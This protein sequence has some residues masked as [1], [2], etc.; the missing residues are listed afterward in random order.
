MCSYLSI[1][2]LRDKSLVLKSILGF[3]SA[4]ECTISVSQQNVLLKA[5]FT[6]QTFQFHWTQYFLGLK[7]QIKKSFP[8]YKR[9]YFIL[10]LSK[11]ITSATLGA[12][13]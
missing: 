4:Q 8:T 10:K 3:K 9:G 1:C 13:F 6:F 2:V 11:Q 7:F 5:C 12:L